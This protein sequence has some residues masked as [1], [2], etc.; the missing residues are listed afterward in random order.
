[1]QS[2]KS[3][4]TPLAKHFKFSDKLS[5]QIEEEEKHMSRVPSFSA[6]GSIMYAMVC[7]KPDISQ[8]VRVV[9]RYMKRPGKTH[10]EAV[11]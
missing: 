7:T 3:V 8:T 11:K 9:S 6:V 2:A 10:W 1:M 5:P 4:S